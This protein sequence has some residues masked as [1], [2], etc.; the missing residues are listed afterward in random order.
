MERKFVDVQY[1]MLEHTESVAN[2]CIK[3]NYT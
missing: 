2:V 1:P 3:K